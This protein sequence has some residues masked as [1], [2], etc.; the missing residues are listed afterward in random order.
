M[1]LATPLVT[2]VRFLKRI[3]HTPIRNEGF[4][5]KLKVE[6]LKETVK[7]KLLHWFGEIMRMKK[8]RMPKSVLERIKNGKTLVGSLQTRKKV[9]VQ[10]HMQANR[11]DW[12]L[13]EKE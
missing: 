7:K 6:S 1:N 11:G 5:D 13:M 12:R 9:Q 2:E 8:N 10:G 3:K 4:G